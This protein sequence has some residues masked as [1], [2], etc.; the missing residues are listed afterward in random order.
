MTFLSR[1]HIL[2]TK[3]RVDLK[4]VC[5]FLDELCA[6]IVLSTNLPSYRTVLLPRGW[7]IHQADKLEE[8]FR[9]PPK[10]FQWIH[11]GHYTKNMLGLFKQIF[12]GDGAGEFADH[13]S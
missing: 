10:Y 1:S 5:N 12:T 3:I 6:I 9:G 11:E 2:E 4:D 13:G 8:L 7:I